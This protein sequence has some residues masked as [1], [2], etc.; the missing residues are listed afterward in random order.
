MNAASDLVE[1]RILDL[2]LDLMSAAQ[3]HSDELMRELTLVAEQMRQEGTA[4]LPTKLVELVG[5]LTESYA[6]F[7]VEQEAKMAAAASSGQRVLPELVYLVPR[8]IAEAV[9]HL[10]N[11]LDEADDYCRSGEHLLT[12]AT[13]PE[14]VA[15]RRWFLREFARQVAG[16]PPTPWP[17]YVDR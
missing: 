3:E 4:G 7:G 13:R 17:Q 14:H 16:E 6:G 9:R 15:L 8:D 5:E 11:L 2:P 12:L 1:V 10:E